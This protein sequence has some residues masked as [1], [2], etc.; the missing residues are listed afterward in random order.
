MQVYELMNRVVDEA[1]GAD[2]RNFLALVQEGVRH[3]WRDYNWRE[4]LTTY[5]FSPHVQGTNGTVASASAT[6]GHTGSNLF[7][8]AHVG[9]TVEIV[10]GDVSSAT[11]TFTIASVTDANTAVMTTP[12]T[13]ASQ[14]GNV[15]LTVKQTAWP[16]P[17]TV[18]RSWLL[19]RGE[20]PNEQRYQNPR[21]YRQLRVADS[22][23]IQFRTV[24]ALGDVV[25]FQ[26]W[27]EVVV[28]AGPAD[29]V[30]V[31][32]DLEDV[33]WWYVMKRVY[34]RLGE[35]FDGPRR[36]ADRMFHAELQKAKK[37]DWEATAQVRRNHRAFWPVE[38]VELAR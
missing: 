14:V 2:L 27:R 12:W 32:G 13:L 33:L 10:A 25:H 1:P 15:V 26:H 17:S 28:P 16:L 24:P 18:R 7:L 6:I 3:I 5:D 9:A 29:V 35:A 31:T 36:G 34:G 8:D 21:D 38:R 20:V 19:Y 23:V 37:R 11:Q 4:G 22:E 30:G